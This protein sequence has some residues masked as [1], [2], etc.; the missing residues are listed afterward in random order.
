MC[1]ENGRFKSC[2][3]TT[4]GS[5]PRVR[6]K[7]ANAVVTGVKSRLI[8]ACAG[9]TQRERCRHPRIRAHPRVCGENS[10]IDLTEV[11][12][13]GSSPRVRG[14]HLVAE[15]ESVAGGLIPACAGKTFLTA[16][17]GTSR[18]AHPRVCGENVRVGE[19]DE[20]EG[21]SSPRVRGKLHAE[22]LNLQRR[23][24]IPA[25]AGKTKLLGVGGFPHEAHPRVCGENINAVADGLVPQG[26]SP[27]VRGKPGGV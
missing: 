17:M 19:G 25:C 26:S 10:R 22:L 2:G 8:P 15:F 6:G 16:V 21:G 20:L 24:L 18:K 9:K 27:R 1:G 11:R 7:L 4:R 5:S 23:R 12:T 3:A 13:A 14:K